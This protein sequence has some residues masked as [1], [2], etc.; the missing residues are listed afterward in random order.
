M[1]KVG[2]CPRIGVPV[3]EFTHRLSLPSA[4]P[5]P[6]SL[7]TRS[8][9]RVFYGILSAHAE[10]IA[11]VIQF[12]AVFQHLTDPVMAPCGNVILLGHKLRPQIYLARRLTS[13][14]AEYISAPLA[15]F[16]T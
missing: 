14:K 9:Q 3:N 12:R 13:A 11:G 5:N 6:C 1:V 7:N 16:K 10:M 4:Y 8:P 15:S 2:K